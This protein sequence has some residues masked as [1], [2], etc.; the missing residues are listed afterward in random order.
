MGCVSTSRNRAKRTRRVRTK[1]P[2][3]LVCDVCGQPISRGLG[4][5]R[6]RV[7]I[8]PYD[9]PSTIINPH[10][11]PAD[12]TNYSPHIGNERLTL[13]NCAI[14]IRQVAKKGEWVMALTSTEY[15]PVRKVSFIA[16]IGDVICR[17]TYAESYDKA[18]LDNH[19]NWD[20]GRFVNI[21]NGYHF[22]PKEIEQDQS[23][24]RVLL[25]RKFKAFGPNTGQELPAQRRE[26]LKHFRAKHAINQRVFDNEIGAIL[27]DELDGPTYHF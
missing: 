21:P 10:G 1:T 25:S 14:F 23:C 13:A 7:Y 22:D 9:R 6:F 11:E 8:R 19:Y 12:Y 2:E 20:E 15:G 5:Q 27:F 3:H 26:I 16:H 4:P 17:R 24:C 18:R